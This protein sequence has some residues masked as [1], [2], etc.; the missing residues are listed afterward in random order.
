LSTPKPFLG[1]LHQEVFSGDRPEGRGDRT[2]GPDWKRSPLIVPGLDT[3][4]SCRKGQ[5]RA[6]ETVP[7]YRIHQTDDRADR[8]LFAPGATV[9]QIDGEPGVL[10]QSPPNIRTG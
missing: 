6:R 4:A 2:A 7:E 5:Y 8:D 1:V 3:I 9:V 10:Q